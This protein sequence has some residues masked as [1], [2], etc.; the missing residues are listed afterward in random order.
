[1]DLLV[2][3]LCDNAE[4]IQGKL[5]VIGAF[6]AIVGQS[7]PAKFS[8]SLALRFYFTPKD[9]GAHSFSIMLLDETENQN[10]KPPQEAEI[11]VN[12]PPEATG[13]STQNMIT[14]LNGT[15]Q[16]AGIYHFVVRIDG[17]VAARVPLRVVQ[18]D[19]VQA[20]PSIDEIPQLT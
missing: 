14:P 12:M 1:M 17:K 19:G 13:F 5:N 8:F 20:A 16:K 4:E 7:F 6:D 2:A 3:T 15:V 10:A 18:Q 11:T 9:R